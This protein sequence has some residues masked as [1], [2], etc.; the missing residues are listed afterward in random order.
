MKHQ[1]CQVRFLGLLLISL[2]VP[3]LAAA[4]GPSPDQPE[5]PVRLK[6]KEK[7]KPG[8]D[9]KP[10]PKLEPSRKDGGAKDDREP[11]PTDLEKEAAAGATR[12][13]GARTPICTR[14]SGAICR[15]PCAGRWTPIPRKSSWSNTATCSSS[16]TPRWPRRGGGK[17]VNSQWSVVSSQ[18]S[19]ASSL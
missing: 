3:G 12:R 9:K 16:T 4:D 6:K 15:K 17:I 14:T 11:A 5:P 7:P 8:E 13:R 1:Q 19:V 2:T 10:A 18:W